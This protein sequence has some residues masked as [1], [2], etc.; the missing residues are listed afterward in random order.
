[1]REVTR[2]SGLV[3]REI[4]YDQIGWQYP[5]IAGQLKPIWGTRDWMIGFGVMYSGYSHVIFP[6]APLLDAVEIL[7]RF[8]AE[9]FR[10]QSPDEATV[11]QRNADLDALFG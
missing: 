10:R 7:E 4:R 2:E 9:T 1:M 11:Q 3:L 6:P 8:L 5:P